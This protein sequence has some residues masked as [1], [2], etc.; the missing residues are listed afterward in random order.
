MDPQV[1]VQNYF[2]LYLLVRMFIISFLCSVGGGFGVAACLSGS[3]Y[4]ETLGYKDA[5]WLDGPTG[6]GVSSVSL[7]TVINV[8]SFLSISCLSN[9]EH[10]SQ[11]TSQNGNIHSIYGKSA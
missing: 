7:V 9:S 5:H 8:T 1:S 10:W 11:K 2:C 3:I 6:R 4:P